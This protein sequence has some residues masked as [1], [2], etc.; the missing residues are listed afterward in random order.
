MDLVSWSKP[1]G[2]AADKT[3]SRGARLLHYYK[4]HTT[5]LKNGVRPNPSVE[6]MTFIFMAFDDFGATL[7]YEG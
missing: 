6:T 4:N 5:V 3:A 7:A 1:T 2:I